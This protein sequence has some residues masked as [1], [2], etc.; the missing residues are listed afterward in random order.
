M[1]DLLQKNFKDLK[2]DFNKK[3]ILK[4]KKVQKNKLVKGENSLV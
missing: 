1:K 2:T 3:N 4:K